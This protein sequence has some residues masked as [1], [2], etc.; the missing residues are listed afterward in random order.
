MRLSVDQPRAPRPEQTGLSDEKIATIL[1]VILE[2]Q[3]REDTN[4]PEQIILF[5]SRAKGTWREGSDIDLALIGSAIKQDDVWRWSER[6]EDELFPWSVDCV[7]IEPTTNPDI[8]AHIRRVG[9]PLH[10][11]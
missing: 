8:I 10:E 9:I 5:G 11:R 4:P 7:L 1:R 3:Q 6:L 2:D